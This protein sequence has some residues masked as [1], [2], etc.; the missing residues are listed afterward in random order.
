MTAS[1]ERVRALAHELGVT[2]L[3]LYAEYNLA[4]SLY[5]L[6]E[7]V[8]RAALHIQRAQAIVE[9]RL[10]GAFRPV[11]PLL[12]ARIFAHA[13][14]L[15]AAADRIAVI[16]TSQAAARAAG[17][18]DL[19]FVPSEEALFA[20]VELAVAGAGA[21]AWD[22]LEA[23]AAEVSVGQERIEVVEMRGLTALRA[24]RRE[25]AAR[26]LGRAA[27]LAAAIPNAMRRRLARDRA[28]VD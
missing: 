20:M 4:E 9:R 17:Q 3:E 28:L 1:F 5:L 27:E 18:L 23:R 25:E 10:A 21:E 19:L 13:G 7:Q 14:N 11:I 16:A 26:A 8:G 22:A 24:G 12:E 6:G 15:A 2:H